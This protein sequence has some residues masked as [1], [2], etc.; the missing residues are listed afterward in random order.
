[1]GWEFTFLVIVGCAVVSL[2]LVLRDH[3]IFKKQVS[4]SG[5]VTERHIGHSEIQFT[6]LSVEWTESI[7]FILPLTQSI[8][9]LRIGDFVHVEYDHI[10]FLRVKPITVRRL[11][12]VEPC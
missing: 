7:H 2:W 12:I 5:F 9:S 4:L 10:P 1:M 3:K 6:L 11:E 8:D